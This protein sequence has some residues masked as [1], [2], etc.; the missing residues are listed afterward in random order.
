MFFQVLPSC[1]L[2]SL[3][4]ICITL[5]QFCCGGVSWDSDQDYFLLS[6]CQ[7]KNADIVKKNILNSYYCPSSKPSLNK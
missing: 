6:D 2:A 4:V 3:Y 7:K 1:S 5:L